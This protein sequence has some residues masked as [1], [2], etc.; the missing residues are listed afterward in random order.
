MTLPEGYAFENPSK[1]GTLYR[2]RRGDKATTTTY[3]G[4][5]SG[6]LIEDRLFIHLAAESNRREGVATANEAAAQQV[7][8]HYRVDTPKFYGKID[9]NINDGNTLEY[10]RFGTQIVPLATTGSSTTRHCPRGSHRYVP[11]PGQ[12]QYR[13]RYLQVHRLPQ[14]CIDFQCRVGRA[15][16]SNLEFNPLD[17]GNPYIS[18]AGNRD[19]SLNGGTPIRNDQP[20]LYS[21]APDAGS[22]PRAAHGPAIPHRQPRVD[23]GVDNMTYR[24]NN[25]GQSMTGPGHARIYSRGNPGASPSRASASP[26][27]ARAISC[28]NT[29]SPLP[30]ACR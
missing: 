23:C 5:A 6:P 3:S 26:A 13:R 15:R 2:Y 21:K 17:S 14:R 16:T 19:P 11:Q 18:G 8:N 4:Y 29:F 25:E 12:V 9:W 20:D 22:D 30:P 10:T 1:P 27:G 28:R 24:A 7:R